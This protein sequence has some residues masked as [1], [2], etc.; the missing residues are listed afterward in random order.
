M[1][2]VKSSGE[3]LQWLRFGDE[4]MLLRPCVDRGRHTGNFCETLDQVGHA[5]WQGGVCL[6]EDRVLSDEWAEGQR[7]LLCYHCKDKHGACRFCRK[8]HGCTPPNW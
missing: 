4:A 8:V 5:G 3:S 7:T 2:A 1:A 6:A